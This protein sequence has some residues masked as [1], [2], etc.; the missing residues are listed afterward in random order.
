MCIKY[1]D[2]TP[3]LTLHYILLKQIEKERKEKGDGG[4]KNNVF[5]SA[6]CG[7]KLL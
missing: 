7:L 2:S 3:R 6:A 1:V 4:A 5:S